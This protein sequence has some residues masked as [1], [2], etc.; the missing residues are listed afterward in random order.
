MNTLGEKRDVVEPRGNLAHDPQRFAAMALFFAG[1]SE[2]QIEV[3]RMPARAHFRAASYDVWN[4]LMRA[5][6]CDRRT[7]GDADSVPNPM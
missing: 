6:S 4:M 5:C 7:S 2:D 1:I 3:T